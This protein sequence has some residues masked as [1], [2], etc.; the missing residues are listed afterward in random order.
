MCLAPT[1][2]V[3]LQLHA[4]TLIHLGPLMPRE[5]TNV[6]ILFLTEVQGGWGKNETRT[7][8]SI[9]AGGVLYTLAKKHVI[10][11]GVQPL[12]LRTDCAS[13]TTEPSQVA[14]TSQLARSGTPQLPT[15]P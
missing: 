3:N 5:N 7:A 13:C 2:R 12:A 1:Y 14:T 11:S 8:L 15:P 4:G 6:H 10:I 9:I